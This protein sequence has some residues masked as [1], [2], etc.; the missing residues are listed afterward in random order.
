MYC[1][2][3]LKLIKEL[4]RHP[5]NL[6]V[7][8]NSEQVAATQLEIKHLFSKYQSIHAAHQHNPDAPP[9]P[10]DI[11]ME[12]IASAAIQRNIRCLMT[13]HQHRLRHLT[14]LAM[15][16]RADG[17]GRKPP[18]IHVRDKL[19]SHEIVFYKEYMKL[20]HGYKVK[21]DDFVDIT[22]NLVPPTSTFIQ[23]RACR[24]LDFETED[25]RRIKLFKGHLDFVRRSDVEK[26][27]E[28]GHLEHVVS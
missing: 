7:S 15:N 22:G 19:S 6:P 3:A 13:Y 12:R 17:A 21:F 27:V 26:Y 28:Q 4:K 23:V 24:D 20:L 9:P 5:D 14:R 25:G 2:E 18:P 16:T 8:Y 11:A 10:T 1:D